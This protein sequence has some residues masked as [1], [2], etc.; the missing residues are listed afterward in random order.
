[1][2][3]DV[4]LVEIAMAYGDRREVFSIVAASWNAPDDAAR[5]LYR[6]AVVVALVAA[7]NGLVGTGKDTPED[8]A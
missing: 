1:M 3:D 4:G 2:P 6:K 5:D 8:G 7:L